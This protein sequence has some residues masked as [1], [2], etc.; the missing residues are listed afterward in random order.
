MAPS[1][2]AFLVSSSKIIFLFVILICQSFELLGVDAELESSKS[3]NELAYRLLQ[4]GN[5]PESFKNSKL[6]LQKAENEN[7]IIEKTR[8]YSN[9]ASNY[10]YLGESNK[11]LSNYLISLNLASQSKN[12]TGELR[13]IN[14][15]ANIYSQLNDQKE[16]IKYRELH[17]KLANEIK[18]PREILISYIGLIG[19]NV[20]VGNLDEARVF[21]N[22][23]K[24]LLE[25]FPEPFLQVYFQFAYATLLEK[26]QRFKEALEAS[27]VA[28][29]ISKQGKY[30]GLIVSTIVNIEEINFTL[31]NFDKVIENTY[32]ALN[33]AL[34]LKL[35]SKIIQSHRLLAKAFEKTSQFKKA[36]EHIK[37]ASNIE[38]NRIQEKVKVLAEI[39]R[40]DRQISETEDDLA[41]SIKDKTI[42]V[43][44]LEQQ[45]K[46]QIIW[47]IGIT[48]FVIIV[49]F[50]IYRR[51]SKIEIYR[52][53]TVNKKLKELDR[54]KDRI[55]KNTSHEL[56]TPLNGIIGL[57][58]VIVE[59]NKNKIEESTLDMIRLIKSSGE[60][61]ALVINDIL[62]MSKSK[63]GHI[64]IINTQFDL[65]AL[66]NDVIKIC[67][68]LAVE[69]DISLNFQREKDR[70]FLFLDKT[71]LQ[72]ILFNIIGNAVKF[73][74]EG[75]VDVKYSIEEYGVILT[76]SDSGIGIPD[77]KI[78]RILEG[79]EQ[80]D[81]SDT[82]SNS[83]SGLGLAI[84][85]NICQALGGQL[86]ISSKIMHGTQVKITLPF[87]G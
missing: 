77:Q 65:I 49:F 70:E 45:N 4:A 66:I 28:L 42:L 11:A 37:Q 75:S 67:S 73:T 31:G 84:S 86:D 44:Q 8:A 6:A 71:R 26:E 18:F 3:V 55:L 43:L 56:R 82:R 62:E 50:F 33:L 46:N 59:E 36:L 34:K 17:L 39:T 30:E 58:E 19:V 53:R 1:L 21:I 29:L 80:V 61:L 22:Q 54:V 64:T 83:G 41:R 60:Q 10:S 23:S 24:K 12:V 72:Q 38:I 68:P 40:I 78:E 32:K 87:A 14:N 63:S 15:I 2:K 5:Y 51:N 57:S 52:Q 48:A 47:L 76:I 25:E 16:T 35:N 27:K 13:A 85:R 7:N 74:D 20:K 79:F 69:K 9:I 81:S